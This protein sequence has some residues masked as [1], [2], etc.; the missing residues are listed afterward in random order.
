MNAMKA[1]I[2]HEVIER[3][4]PILGFKRTEETVF[5]N[6]GSAVKFVTYPVM[7]AGKII[8]MRL[9]AI[10]MHPP[11][12]NKDPGAKGESRRPAFPFPHPS[13]S[14]RNAPGTMQLPA[15]SGPDH[16]SNGRRFLV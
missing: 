7:D 12:P 2:R 16:A 9:D 15:P 8:D 10:R 5:Y 4:C 1:Q 11:I 6:D 14:I 13:Y 3:T